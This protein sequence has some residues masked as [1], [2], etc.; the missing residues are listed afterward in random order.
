MKKISFMILVILS[1]TIV[2]ADIYD[3]N[4]T[5]TPTMSNVTYNLSLD[6]TCDRVDVG[7]ICVNFT[8]GYFDGRN[9]CQQRS[10]STVLPIENVTPSVVMLAPLNN[11]VSNTDIFNFRFN[12]IG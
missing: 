6:L 10:S 1:M 7:T 9:I 4:T 8:G 12:I 2:C 3:T 5:F 11:T